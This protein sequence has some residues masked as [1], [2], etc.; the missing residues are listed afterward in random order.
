MLYKQLIFSLYNFFKFYLRENNI[1][2]I[3]RNSTANL[4]NRIKWIQKNQM[5][6]IGCM[7]I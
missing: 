3:T 4:K 2:V 6:L 1:I 5:Q 7:I